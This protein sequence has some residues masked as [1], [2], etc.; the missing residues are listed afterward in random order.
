MKL[1]SQTK[2]HEDEMLSL[3]IQLR[4]SGKLDRKIWLEAFEKFRKPD[5]TDEQFEHRIFKLYWQTKPKILRY[6]QMIKAIHELKAQGKSDRQA[7]QE[8]KIPAGTVKTLL[9]KAK[10][11]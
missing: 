4:E 11:A 8:L 7:A 9:R 3:A 6:R 2:P 5:E 1:M 10:K